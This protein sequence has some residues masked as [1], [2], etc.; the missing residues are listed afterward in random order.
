[1]KL[2][3]LGKCDKHLIYP[4]IGGVSN[5]IINIILQFFNNDVELN[6]HPVMKGINAGL[7]MS[8]AI[9]PYI[10]NIKILKKNKREK[11][12]YNIKIL[13]RKNK[14]KVL[15]IKI[16]K[17]IILLLC[18]FLDFTQKILVFLFHYA[19]TGNT[20]VFN[21]I[22]L[23]VFTSMLSK[24]KL[25]KHQYVSIGIMVLCGIGIN[26]V[27]LYPMEIK[28]LPLFFLDMIIEIIYTLAITLAKYGMD[29]KFCSPFEI[30]FYEG[31]LAFIFNIIFLIIS[32]NIPLADDFKY[33]SLFTI[34]E[35]KGK[36]YL[37]NFYSHF[38]KLNVIEVS[39]FIVSMIGR[40][41]F[42]LFSHITIKYFTSSHVFLILIMGEMSS[43]DFRDRN[44]DV[45]FIFSI[46]IFIIEF[47]MILI[48]CEIIELN[49]CGLEK[50][51]KKNILER[52]MLAEYEDNKEVELAN[53]SIEIS[54]GFEINL[55]SS[56]TLNDSDKL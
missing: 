46:I 22:F 4:L 5:L 55:D 21:I 43:I 13:Q 40:L 3:S 15:S 19:L 51:T 33:N 6:R 23:N 9:I 42:N 48:F 7:G 56:Y 17:Y 10:Y 53:N 41:L 27:N 54:E 28:E 36:K 52:A 1:M 29:Y 24:N 30:T 37:D 11:I 34:T 2:I 32:T 49:F 45:R 25:Y 16:E 12:L 31:F 20:W 26:I 44:K 50:N 35:Y 8:L 18:S 39:L 38:D 47:L 14:T